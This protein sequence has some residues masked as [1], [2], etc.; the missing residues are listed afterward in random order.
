M[1]SY[2][3]NDD[4]FNEFKNIK[5]ETIN[6]VLVDLPY[7][8]FDTK[9]KGETQ[10]YWDV[11]FDLDKMWKKLTRITTAG[12]LFVF[13]CNAKF[14]YRLIESNESGFKY[15]LIWRKFNAPNFLSANKRVLCNHELI[16]IFKKNERYTDHDAKFNHPLRSYFRKLKEHIGES[17]KEIDKKVGNM[18]FHHCFSRTQFGIC[19]RKNYEKLNTIYKLSKNYPDYLDYDQIKKLV[20]TQKMTCVYNPQ[21]WQGEPFIRKDKRYKCTKRL[22]YGKKEIN[23]DNPSGLRHPLSVIDCKYDKEKIHTTQKPVEL[24]EFLIKSYSNEGDTVIDF[25]M[26][27]GSTIIACLN[28]NRK[29]IGIEKDPDIFERAKTRIENHIEKLKN[30]PKEEEEEEE[31]EEEVDISDLEI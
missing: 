8:C 23:N 18:G 1:I 9:D 30:K 25:T 11:Q 5:N 28:S 16:Y 13:F 24:C 20:E 4:C 22:N 6:M 14:G 19:T 15:D 2:I 31:E 3:K 27:S 29:Y 17:I 26:G 12:C 10:A 21:K 7:G